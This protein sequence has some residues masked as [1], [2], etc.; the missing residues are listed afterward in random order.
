MNFSRD[1]FNCSFLQ[2]KK[3]LRSM[4]VAL[5]SSEQLVMKL[6]QRTHKCGRPSYFESE[7]VLNDQQEE[8]MKIKYV[9]WLFEDDI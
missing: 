4:E 9:S 7:P 5:E 8:N 3:F 6:N 1:V 2:M